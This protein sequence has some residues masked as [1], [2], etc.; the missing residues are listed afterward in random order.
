MGRTDILT[1]NGVAYSGRKGPSGIVPTGVISWSSDSNAQ[2]MGWKLCIKNEDTWNVGAPPLSA[3]AGNS[4][5]AV[6][7]GSGATTS[8][9]GSV[10]G[11]RSSGGNGSSFPWV[12][13]LGVLLPLMSA[14][15]YFW[16]RLSSRR[17]SYEVS[18][19]G[20]PMHYGRKYIH[21]DDL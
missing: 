9:S 5:V 4:Q 7:A 3:T 21:L 8:G 20:S 15:G 2:D 16:Y 10:R 6:N 19:R 17:Q 1:V 14:A 11:G 18:A 13:M 12:T